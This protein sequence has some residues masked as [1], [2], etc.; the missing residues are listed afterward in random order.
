MKFLKGTFGGGFKAISEKK[1]KCILG[2]HFEKIRGG[3]PRRINKG[4]HGV[5]F[6][7][8][9]PGTISEKMETPQK[10][11]WGI[12]ERYWKGILGEVSEY[13]SRQI[14]KVIYEFVK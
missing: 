14:L 7:D 12:F 2:G 13:I 1:T 8:K 4:I 6:K 3:V 10:N 9:I 5:I 11:G